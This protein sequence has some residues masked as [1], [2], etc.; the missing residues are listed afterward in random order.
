M[1]RNRKTVNVVLPPK[2]QRLF[3]PA[4]YK[5]YYEGSGGAKCLARGTKI[6]MADVTLRCVED[7]VA[8]ESVMGADTELALF[9][10]SNSLLTGL[11]LCV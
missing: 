11:M 9:I 2:F 1:A 7:V 3:K 4:R 10:V 8:G 6:I 5:I